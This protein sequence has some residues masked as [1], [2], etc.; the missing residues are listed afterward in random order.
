MRVVLA[1]LKS[2]RGFVS[3]DTVVGGYGSRLD[4]FS[5]VTAV[6]AY[7]KKQFHDVPSVHMAYLAAILARAGHEVQLDA[8]RAGR[9]RR[10]ARAVVARRLQER[11]R[12]GRSDARARR[13]GRV[14]RH[15]GVEDAGAVRRSLR[16][17]PERRA[18]SR[19]DAAGAGRS[20]RRAS[21]SASRST[22]STRCRFRAGIWSPRTARKLGHQVVRRGRSAAAIRCSPAA[23]ARSSAP[24]ARTGSSPAT[25]RARSRTSST[26]SSGCATS[27]RGRTSSSAIRCSPSSATAVSSCATRSARAA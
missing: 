15:H 23:A 5:R 7:L 19:R 8:R 6:M 2:N 10:R 13:Q 25:A 24:T 20:S 22:I 17:H 3:K 18:G 12:V 16:L 11:D 14:H 1:D 9:R 21:S 26:R 4:P 27:I